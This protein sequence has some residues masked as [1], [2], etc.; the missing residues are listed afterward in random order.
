M[1]YK[2]AVFDLD[3]TLLNDQHEIS[4]K[5]KKALARLKE[6]G[7]EVVLA[8]GRS[9]LL[10]KEYIQEL[11]LQIPVISCNGA[12]IRNPM[13]KEIYKKEPMPADLVEKIIKICH[14]K[15]LIYMAYSSDFIYTIPNERLA[16]FE[17]R[18]QQLDAQCQIPFKVSQAVTEI[19]ADEIY[20]VLI[21]ENDQAQFQAIQR[22]FLSLEGLEVV[23]SSKGLLD[24]MAQGVSKKAGLAFLAGH[25]KITMDQIVA[26]GDNY[27]DME[28][29][30]AAGKVITTANAVAEIKA[31][32]DYISLSNN[33]SGVGHAIEQYLGIDLR[34][35]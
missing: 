18:N 23:Q 6:E 15:K 14:E 2:L 7:C 30:K 22:D 28:M 8:T 26:F 20:K 11:H 12:L 24:L 10:I 29:L 9:D 34:I 31:I 27:N 32:A 25:F 16:Y 17:M 3:G 1:D 21:I 13:T 4:E 33:E 5:N 19:A 35:D